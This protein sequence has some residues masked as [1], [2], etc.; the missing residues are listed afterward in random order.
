[1]SD[2][3]DLNNMICLDIYLSALSEDKYGEVIHKIRSRPVFPLLSWDLSGNYTHNN[4]ST[5]GKID[6]RLQLL[7]LA[8]QHNWQSDIGSLLADPYEALVL[9]DINQVI[10]WA[11]PG[12]TAMTGYS[13]KYAIGR[14]PKFLQGKNT[15]AAVRNK[16]RKQL[17]AKRPFTATIIN[18]RKNKEEYLCQVKIIPLRNDLDEITHFI[19]LEKEAV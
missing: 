16:I 10:C 11:S 9:T 17:Q 14:T 2:N 8:A 15:S 18:Y 1:M 12:F 4:S 3:D 19:A 7:Q 5:D 6:D 13:V